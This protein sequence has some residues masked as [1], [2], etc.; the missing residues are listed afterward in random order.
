MCVK[1]RDE[2]RA[3]TAK[4]RAKRRDSQVARAGTQ[5]IFHRPNKFQ[6]RLGPR[7]F[8]KSLSMI[9]L[10]CLLICAFHQRSGLI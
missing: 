7:A 6:K 2:L 5:L 1:E 3:I 4:R 8:D 9:I 10:N